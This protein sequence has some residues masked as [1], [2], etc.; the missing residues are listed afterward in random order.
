MAPSLVDR[1]VDDVAERVHKKDQ[2][3]GN[4]KEAFS[5]SAATTNY[6]AELNG[7]DK[8]P[9]AKFP[10]YLPCKQ[11]RNFLRT[12]NRSDANSGQTGTR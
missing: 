10:N 11:S 12:V 9:P 6:E 4:Y 8:A 7:S 5:Q 2:Q 3:Q 1:T